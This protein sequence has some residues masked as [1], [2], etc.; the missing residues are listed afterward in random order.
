VD[1]TKD[2]FLHK[3]LRNFKSVFITLS[4]VKDSSGI[5]YGMK[6]NKDRANNLTT[7]QQVEVGIQNFIEK[8]DILL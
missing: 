6:C 5:L 8:S 3:R 2:F 1:V 4:R 7:A